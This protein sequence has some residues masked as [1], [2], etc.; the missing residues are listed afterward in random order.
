MRLTIKPS[1][2]EG[3]HAKH[4]DGR[5]NDLVETHLDG[6]RGDVVWGGGVVEVGVVLGWSCF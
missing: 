1:H 6:E 2:Y 3:Q 5:Q 4:G